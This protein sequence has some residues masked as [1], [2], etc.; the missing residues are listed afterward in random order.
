MNALLAQFIAEAREFLQGISASLMALEER[1]DD[2]DRMT[3]LFRQVH[4]LK[5]NSGL[6]DF[7]AMTRVLHAGE[8]LM[9]AVRHGSVPFGSRIT[10]ALLD[11]MDFVSQLFDEIAQH[12]RLDA[13]RD[14]AAAQVAQRLR[15]L[16][17]ARVE[18]LAE[19]T[20]AAPADAQAAHHAP[21]AAAL[22]RLRALVPALQTQ[23]LTLP[24][25]ERMALYARAR[26][27]QALTWIDY[28][29]EPECFFK[30]EDPF[31][32][33]L[34]TPGFA[35][36]GVQA[37]S[38][39]PALAQLDAYRC[40][41]RFGG[42]STAARAELDAHFRYVP[43]QVEFIDLPALLM[44]LPAGDANGGPVYE[45]FVVE[46]LALLEQRDWDGLRRAA[47]SLLE[48]SSPA[49]WLSSALR[50]LLCL[51]D[52]PG[53]RADALRALVE[54]VQ[55]LSPPDWLAH[56]DTAAPAAAVP[57]AVGALAEP[58]A[59]PVID[60]APEAQTP[61]P[62]LSATQRQALE[63][64][65]LAQR[66]ILALPVDAG[67]AGRLRAVA[68]TLTG[69]AKT[70][71]QQ[72]RLPALDQALAQARAEHSPAPLLAWLDAFDA[73][74][75]SPGRV[76]ATAV[77][78]PLAVQAPSPAVSSAVSPA[79]IEGTAMV[80]PAEP[81]ALAEAR[82]PR[83]ADEASAAAKT[84]RV[85]QVKI[86]RLMNLIGEMVVAK[87][88]L[89]YLATRAEN[90]YGVREL[91]RE[92]KSQYGVINRIAEEMQD[93]IMQVRMMP[94]SFVFQRFPRLVRD[95]SHKLGKE[96]DLVLEGEN[97]EADKN[98]IEAL[99]DPL[100]HIVRNSLDHGLEPPA[101]RRA[102]GKPERGRLQ[103]SARQESDHVTIEIVD[104][105]RGIDPLTIKRKAYEK[106]LIDEERLEQ[107]SDQDAVNLVFLPGFSTAESVTDLSGR[108][109]GMDVVRSAIDK[110]GGT[111]LLGSVP[112]R[113]TRLSLSLPLSM[114]ITN[115]MIIESAG[116]IFGF[117]M[118]AVVETVRLPRAQVRY[119]KQR[120]TTVL[121]DKV[122]PLFSLNALLALPAEQRLNA[123]DEFALL[124]LRLG[125]EP[126]GLLIDGFRET[127]DIILKP[128]PGVLGSLRGYAGSALLGDGSVLMVLD[129]K[130]LF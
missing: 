127:A 37:R 128:L 126:V 97:T 36:A 106:G 119:F 113:G 8:D 80:P 73:A 109:V 26:G 125:Q 2:A 85:D 112:G 70:L 79:V 11:A 62:A 84:V 50:W 56:L 65:L 72:S 68:M 21:A 48:L 28:Q 96:V 66:S 47:H 15:E 124:V 78:T 71:G 86:D 88:A 44:V 34:R 39:W 91:A 58:P 59:V 81:A 12:E 9:D 32:L 110:V 98:V 64:L 117:P 46:A 54:S 107:L 111:V 89:P 30:G 25:A 20:S 16:L 1:P 123:Q 17:P 61:W 121:R 40:E 43:E 53:E 115:V 24:E 5:G 52:A 13:S 100:I 95:L 27:G 55:T 130:E 87:N 6:F 129:H 118:E 23:L 74:C 94:V 82:P 122:M 108:G 49:L 31:W 60:Q 90:Q 41:L 4:T 29:P 83:R 63:A 102:C 42:V 69:C 116:Q 77:P 93:A 103:I 67:A 104:D 22:A 57:L 3:E 105:G 10:D 51:L 101:V 14:H 45:D 18:A 99:A 35:V 75:L 7:P 92:I 38:P 19:P 120:A 76:A 33:A 114:A